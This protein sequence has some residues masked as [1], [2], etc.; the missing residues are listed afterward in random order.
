MQWCNQH[1]DCRDRSDEKNCKVLVLGEGYNK[2]VPPVPVDGRDNGKVSVSVFIDI[3]KL[4]DIDKED[5]SID[6]QFSIFLK[7]VEDRATYQNLKT[8]WS[9]NALTQEDIQLLWLP[10]VI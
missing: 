4:V 8:R 2:N 1:P 6:I 9:L 7:W 5:Y 3:L 10:K